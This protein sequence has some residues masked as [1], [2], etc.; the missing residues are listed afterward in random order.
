M[1]EVH[2][3][4]GGTPWCKNNKEFVGENFLLAQN[5]GRQSHSHMCKMLKYQVDT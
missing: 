3:A 1:Q 4:H 2:D 5:E